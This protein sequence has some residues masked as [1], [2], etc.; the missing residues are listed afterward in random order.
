MTDNSR[1]ENIPDLKG[2]IHSA[3]RSKKRHKQKA[4]SP[5]LC[6]TYLVIQ[7]QRNKFWEQVRQEN[8]AKEGGRKQRNKKKKKN[9]KSPLKDRR[10]SRTERTGKKKQNPN[11]L[12]CRAKAKETRQDDYREKKSKY[13]RCF[14]TRGK[15]WDDERANSEKKELQSK[16]NTLNRFST[17]LPHQP[18]ICRK[19]ALIYYL[20]AFYSSDYNSWTSRQLLK[21]RI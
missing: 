3:T 19:A 13:F 16:W 20:N 18:H 11:G 10:D 12:S 21:D 1:T 2:V 17:P 4:S 6:S 15:G 8:W 9:S 5:H 7:S 14:K